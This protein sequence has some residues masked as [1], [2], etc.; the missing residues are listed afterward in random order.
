MTTF[1]DKDIVS[2]DKQ[3]FQS[4][5]CAI[6]YITENYR[7]WCQIGR[8]TETTLVSVEHHDGNIVVRYTL[9]EE[10]FVEDPEREEYFDIRHTIMTTVSK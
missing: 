3:L 9:D 6:E 1:Y 5:S 2:V 10:D 7:D 8:Y 4:T